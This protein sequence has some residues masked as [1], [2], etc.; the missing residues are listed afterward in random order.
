MRVDACGSADG[1]EA[2]VGEGR[3]HATSA[4][5]SRSSC[6]ALAAIGAAAAQSTWLTTISR[7]PRSSVSSPTGASLAYA[8]SGAEWRRA[9]LRRAAAGAAAPPADARAA[10]V[11]RS[12]R[13][14]SSCTCA[15]RPSARAARGRAAARR[16]ER[17]SRARYAATP[18]GCTWC[19]ALT[20]AAHGSSTARRLLR[21]ASW[22]LATARR[23]ER[24]SRSNCSRCRARWRSRTSC[25]SSHRVRASVDAQP[26]LRR[27]RVG[28][29]VGAEP[30]ESHHVVTHAR[31]KHSNWRS[32]NAPRHA[33][34][35]SRPPREWAQLLQQQQAAAGRQ[36]AF[37]QAMQPPR[38][39][40]PAQARRRQNRWR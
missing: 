7:P 14:L 16:A 38:W 15:S 2:H 9:R 40:F 36:H 6:N 1:G 29:G 34:G 32:K 5:H 13:A 39:P 11:G 23:C 12:C 35:T 33:R 4:S 20:P 22:G 24:A 28:V 25:S 30:G 3:W 31:A 21:A 10:G 26:F 19:T 18:G 27:V 37:A 8:S 17:R